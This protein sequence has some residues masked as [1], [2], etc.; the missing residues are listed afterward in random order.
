M[1]K[2]FAK[3]SKI[4]I[5]PECGGNGTIFKR[6]SVCDTDIIK[7]PICKGARVIREVTERYLEDV[8]SGQQ[9]DE[10]RY[11]TDVY[12][13]TS[14]KHEE[15]YKQIEKALGFKLFYWQK[16]YIETGCFRQAGI[17]T[18]K[19]IKQLLDV[20]AGIMNLSTEKDC[21]YYADGEY[22][23]HWAIYKQEVK[24]IYEKLLQNKLPVRKVIFTKL[25]AIESNEL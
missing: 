25:E 20:D 6:I 16:T 9:E 23:M 22:R 15:L 11:M 4:I 3:T 17:T 21:R 10:R 1:I 5:C 2:N 24:R 14:S 13:S 8:E 7:C 18:A 19:I 12:R